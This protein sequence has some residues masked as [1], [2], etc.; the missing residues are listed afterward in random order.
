MLVPS[1]MLLG[2]ALDHSRFRRASEKVGE[3]L[4]G[5]PAAVFEGTALT[6]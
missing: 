3:N 5:R 6:A 1:G 4:P 2:R